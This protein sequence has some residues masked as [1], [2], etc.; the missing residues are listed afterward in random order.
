MRR[1]GKRSG[2]KGRESGSRKGNWEK[3][4]GEGSSKGERRTDE[5]KRGYEGKNKNRRIKM[6]P[7]VS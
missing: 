6:K 5:E 1:E 7:N 2:Q 3:R 4:R